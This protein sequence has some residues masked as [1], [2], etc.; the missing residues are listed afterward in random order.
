MLGCKGD[1]HNPQHSHRL[2]RVLIGLGF[3]VEGSKQH[4]AT[5]PCCASTAKSGLGVCAAEN[6]TGTGSPKTVDMLHGTG[7]AIPFSVSY[8]PIVGAMIHLKA[9][10]VFHGAD[11]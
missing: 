1:S 10:T 3:L 11:S 5:S 6:I 4:P 2:I 9:S 7:K 8:S